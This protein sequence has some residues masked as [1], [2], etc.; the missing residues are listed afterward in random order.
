MTVAPFISTLNVKT[1]AAHKHVHVIMVSMVMA[2][3]V[4]K[5]INVY[6]EMILMRMLHAVTLLV[7]ANVPVMGL[8]NL[9]PTLIN[10]SWFFLVI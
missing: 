2:E 8:T 6:P 4:V 9:V 3:L 7:I 1:F 10:V 5:S